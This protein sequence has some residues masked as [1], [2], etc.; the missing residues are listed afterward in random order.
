MEGFAFEEISKNQSKRRNIFYGHRRILKLP[1]AGREIW[2]TFLPQVIADRSW[3]LWSL[4]IQGKTFKIYISSF[5]DLS[6]LDPKFREVNWRIL[7]Q[8]LQLLFWEAAL[9]P[10][11][12]SLE[13]F[14]SDKIS[15]VSIEES[16]HMTK[17]ASKMVGFH[18]YIPSERQSFVGYWQAE[19][20]ALDE[21]LQN[22]WEHQAVLPLRTY[23][24]LRVDY[25]LDL[26][27]TE[28]SREC[29]EKIQEEDL[30]LL[31]HYSLEPRTVSQLRGLEPFQVYVIP[32]KEGF[33]VQK[34]Q[35]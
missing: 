22:L 6:H 17:D 29:Y 27:S 30:I 15:L 2:L 12:D 3:S 4:K 10:L 20:A 26:G 19:D 16:V 25:A 7:P 33:H 24:D 31:D 11:F 32:C 34:V 14:L 1:N 23:D 21:L 9:S 8:R 18:A 5:P 13:S 35:F 28:L